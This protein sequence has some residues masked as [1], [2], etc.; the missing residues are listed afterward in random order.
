METPMMANNGA[1]SDRAEH[2]GLIFHEIA[3]N[4]FPFMMGTNERKYAWMDEGW[5][6]FFPTDLV[7][8]YEPESG[9]RERRVRSYV[10]EAGFETDLP[11]LTPS[12]SYQ[13]KSARLG[14]Y[15]KPTN[16]YYEL[17]ELLGEELFKRALLE[18]INRWYGKHPLPQDFFFTFDHVA[19]E[20]LSWFWN[21]W[22]YEYGYPDLALT[23][24]KEENGNA[25][26]KIKKLGNI[27]TRIEL[28]FELENGKNIKVS[29]S[30]KVW[31]DGKDEITI[32]CKTSDKIRKVTLGNKNIADVNEKNNIL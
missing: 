26:V 6:S 16:A 20:Y 19:G 13:T 4:Y 21:P 31:K 22:F 9:Y 3:H 17:V 32:Q 10:Q 2:I 27:P 11:L 23:D 5:A 14:F 24:L 7:Q 28:L 8:A 18:F 1:P 25:T 12:Y 29:E 30:A 15:D